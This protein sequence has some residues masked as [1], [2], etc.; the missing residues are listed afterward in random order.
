M[1]LLKSLIKAKGSFLCR[2]SSDCAVGQTDVFED[3][4]AAIIQI[5]ISGCRLRVLM[6][7]KLFVRR[8]VNPRHLHPF[9]FKLEFVRLRQ[10]LQRVL[11][12]RLSYEANKGLSQ[13]LKEPATGS[14]LRVHSIIVHD[15]IP[16]VSISDRLVDAFLRPMLT[17]ALLPK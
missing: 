1:N 11:S 12:K 6:R 3:N 13:S 10:D 17:S 5:N 7:R 4:R 8:V 2:R 16:P 15:A 14:L 9:V